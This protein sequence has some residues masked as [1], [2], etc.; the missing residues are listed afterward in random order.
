MI[1]KPNMQNVQNVSN[2]YQNGQIIDQNNNKINLNWTN[3]PVS[4]QARI[5][6]TNQQIYPQP[7]FQNVRIV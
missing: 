4:T 1:L 2:I 6:Q 5:Q 7:Y 3:I